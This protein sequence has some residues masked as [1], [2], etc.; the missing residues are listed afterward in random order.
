MVLYK[1]KQASHMYE[2]RGIPLQGFA[3]RTVFV[4][5]SAK[6]VTC[7]SGVMHN[8]VQFGMVASVCVT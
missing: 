8:N 4:S 1:Q 2:K 3:V 6:Q 5:V 7:P